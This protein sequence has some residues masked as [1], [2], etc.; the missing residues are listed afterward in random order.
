MMLSMFR[1]S[2]R[3]SILAITVASGPT[4]PDQG[5]VL[6]EAGEGQRELPHPERPRDADR[7]HV[8]VGEGRQRGAGSTVRPCWTGP[9]RLQHHRGRAGRARLG[10]PQQRPL[11]STLSSLRDAGLQGHARPQDQLLLGADTGRPRP[12]HRPASLEGHVRRHRPAAD[13]RPS[14]SRQTGWWSSSGSVDGRRQR[15]PPACGTG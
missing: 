10:D 14:V 15:P 7:L 13:L 1:D 5:D 9:A 11:K 3:L 2:S 8:L 12:A 4:A 6:G